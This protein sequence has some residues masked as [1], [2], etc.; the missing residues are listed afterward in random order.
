MI[1]TLA[2][3]ELLTNLLTYR[4]AVALVF[5]VALSVLTTAIGSIDFSRNVEAYQQEVRQQRQELEEATVYSQTQHSILLPPQPLAI[6]SRGLIGLAPQSYGVNVGYVG[7]ASWPMNFGAINPY[8][9]ALGQID[10]VTVVAVLL[11]FLAVVLAY[12]GICGER[13]R[14]TLKVLL[15]NPVPRASV[16]L[17][18]LLGG[19]V[20]LW[21]PLTV[22]FVLCLLIVLANGD[23]HF[24]AG[25]WVRL[26]IL[27]A[28]TCLFL[29]Q[30]FALSLLVSTLVRDSDTSLIVCL[31]LW[32]VGGVGYITALPSL[33]RYGHE[34]TPHQDYMNASRELWDGFNRE[35]EEWDAAHP[36]PDEVYFQ[37]LENDGVRRFYHPVA[38]R[39]WAERNAVEIDKVMEVA[40]RS[41]QARF[42]AWDPLAQQGYSVDRWSRLSPFTN[43]Q[44]LAYQVARTTLDDLFHI[45]QAAR[46]YRRT[47]IDYLRSKRAMSSPRWFTDDPPDQVPMVPDPQSL[48]AADLARDSAYMQSRRAWA[49]EQQ[50]RAGDD[51]RRRLDLSDMPKFGASWQRTLGESLAAMTPGLVALVVTSGL[52]VLVASVRFS[53]YDPS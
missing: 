49:D 12:D 26:G 23:V 28:V 24:A 20:S 43:Y 32:L 47:Y 41:Y 6:F 1:W 51:D 40:D 38:Y 46:D 16:V 17:G 34:E 10:L 13:E 31:F 44:V 11:S 33:S 14:G 50:A 5:T 36:R 35:M 30:V 7:R 9:K 52:S 21:V 4:L 15:T 48:T 25:D 39:W 2:R 8:L 29:A 37:G 19:V 45:G 53:T 18:K 22:A 3:K 42:A 27:Y